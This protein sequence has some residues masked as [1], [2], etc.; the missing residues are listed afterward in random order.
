MY[1]P[2]PIRISGLVFKSE[3]D[4]L[5]DIRVPF[6]VLPKSDDYFKIGQ[7]SREKGSRG[8]PV[9]CPDLKPNVN[10]SCGGGPGLAH[11]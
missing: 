1:E 10:F 4:P 9:S 6:P 5:P 7:T 11:N 8:G 3:P 2:D